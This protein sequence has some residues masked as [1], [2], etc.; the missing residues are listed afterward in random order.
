MENTG[1]DDPNQD[2]PRP[3]LTLGS[4]LPPPPEEGSR[5]HAAWPGL[6][7][8]PYKGDP[9]DKVTPTVRRHRLGS[10]G[11]RRC[12][13]GLED[14]KAGRER[15]RFLASGPQS[16]RHTLFVIDASYAGID[17]HR[18]RKGGPSLP[19]PWPV[20]SGIPPC[21]A[22]GQPKGPAPPNEA[23]PS[24]GEP[25]GPVPWLS[26]SLGRRGPAGPLCR[27]SKRPS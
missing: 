24:L 23:S 27:T 14:G 17:H 19:L 1:P 3:C 21:T 4:L 26:V 9:R 5:P 11:G 16:S 2:S 18:S 7:L 6:R 15:P 8:P 22:T 13:V 12:P 10:S 20:E 25:L